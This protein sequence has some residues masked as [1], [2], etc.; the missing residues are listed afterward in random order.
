MRNRE[1]FA[2]LLAV[3]PCRL[4]R[5]GKVVSPVLAPGDCRIV[6][7]GGDTLMLEIPG[8][9]PP[10]RPVQM[11]TATSDQVFLGCARDGLV[12]ELLPDEAHC[13]PGAM[14]LAQQRSF[15]NC[16]LRRLLQRRLAAP[17]RL[18]LLAST[19]D[20]L[21]RF[22]SRFG[23]LIIRHAAG[24]SSG[25]ALYP[26]QGV[27]AAAAFLS[28]ALVWFAHCRGCRRPFDQDLFLLF[29]ADLFL[30]VLGRLELLNRQLVRPRI[31]R[32]DLDA[33]ELEEIDPAVVRDRTSLPVSFDFFQPRP[34]HVNPLAREVVE[35]FYPHLQ[36]EKTPHSFDLVTC[37]GLPLM[38][39]F[40][41]RPADVFIGW[42]APL[43]AWRDWTPQ[44]LGGWI[45]DVI[46]T[47]RD[48]SPAPLRDIFRLFPERWM[49]Y[50]LLQNIQ[51]LEPDFQPNWTYRQVPVYRGTGRS[52]M[53][54]LSLTADNRLAV[55]EIKAADHDALLFQALDY[56]ERV[57]EGLQNGAFQRS[58]YFSGVRLRPDPP[59]LILVTPL[60]RFHRN[61]RVLAGFLDRSIPIRMAEW[62]IRWRREWR[63]IRRT[64]I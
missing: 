39:I 25:M 44:R 2:V 61:L 23:R 64:R 24:L 27:E 43:G 31:L 5:D 42:T 53:D 45:E 63:V 56:W 6:D 49:E 28:A 7:G 50:L 52:V 51:R 34:L 12:L 1:E 18:E 11:D 60:F 22:S 41:P 36:H 16:R 46:R 33:G 62:N 9:L 19:R 15:Y 20:P 37:R 32:Y 47:R 54:V 29:H 48:P 30:H 14:G 3:S 8:L 13:P 55:I 38:H 35:R 26:F 21:L 40:G 17:S 59:W 4:R 58:G 57:R 10:V